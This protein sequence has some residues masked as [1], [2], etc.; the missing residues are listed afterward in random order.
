MSLLFVCVIEFANKMIASI[1][2]RSFVRIQ[3]T[4]PLTNFR[5]A[6]VYSEIKLPC[7]RGPRQLQGKSEKGK[8]YSR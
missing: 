3:N 2:A 4:N 5:Y 7:E 1:V 8:L 6:S